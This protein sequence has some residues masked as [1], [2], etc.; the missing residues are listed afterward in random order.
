MDILLEGLEARAARDFIKSLPGVTVLVA[1]PHMACRC[2]MSR[3]GDSIPQPLHPRARLDFSDFAAV[4]NPI[5]PTKAM[6][7]VADS[8]PPTK[9]EAAN[10]IPPT[11][12]TEPCART[13]GQSGWKGC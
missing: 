1:A 8:I 9:A 11:K 12:A 3:T 10:P 2:V 5:P 7:A 4:A 6:E 13:P